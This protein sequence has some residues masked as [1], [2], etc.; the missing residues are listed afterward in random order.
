[1]VRNI[2]S[3]FNLNWDVRRWPI[4]WGE[5]LTGIVPSSLLWKE[6]LEQTWTGDLDCPKQFDFLK[7]TSDSDA[8]VYMIN[9]ESRC[10]TFANLFEVVNF[11]LD[12]FFLD[13]EIQIITLN[14]FLGSPFR[15]LNASVWSALCLTRDPRSVPKLYFLFWAIYRGDTFAQMERK[16]QDWWLRPLQD[17]QQ[18]TWMFVKA[19]FIKKQNYWAK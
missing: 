16:C 12:N 3:L 15:C 8:P 19:H 11:F 10:F 17:P 6:K 9:V 18:R 14:A 7:E 1:M 13:L 4:P 2:T 5:N